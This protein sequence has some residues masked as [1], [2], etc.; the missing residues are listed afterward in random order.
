MSYLG[1]YPGQGVCFEY[2]TDDYGFLV[3]DLWTDTDHGGGLPTSKSTS[4]CAFIVAGPNGTRC[5]MEWS[6]KLQEYVALSS[7]EAET[8]G[9]VHAL[10]RVGFPGQIILEQLFDDRQSSFHLRVNIDNSAAEVGA[11]T[12]ITKEM[13]YLRKTQRISES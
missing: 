8:V 6:A 12:G 4:G 5:L 2:Y 1:T 9:V 7:G 11:K 10:L 13:K 3:N